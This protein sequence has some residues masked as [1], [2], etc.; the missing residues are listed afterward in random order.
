MI[1]V[2]VMTKEKQLEVDVPFARIEDSDIAWYWI[3]FCE[4][5]EEEKILL[6]TYFQFHPLA[7][8]DC[9]HFLQRPKI[10]YYDGYQFFI[11][12]EM[13]KETFLGEE[14][15]VF[16]SD[17]FIITYHEK[18]SI[19][20]ERAWVKL[21]ASKSKKKDPLYAFY[22]ILDEIVDDYFPITYELEDKLNNLEDKASKKMSIVTKE[23]YHIRKELL[24]IRKIILPMRELLYRILN[25]NHLT[26][27]KGERSYFED[28][29]DHLI[30][31]SEIIEVNR[32]LSSDIR[33]N[34]LSVNAHRMNSIM[35]VLTVIT[36]IFMPLTFIAGVY[37]MN[38]SNMPELQTKYGYFVVLVVMFLIAW[39]MF[40]W[41][42][43][44]GWFDM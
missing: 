44:K 11:L 33:D 18:K 30:R 13:N 39:S 9:L 27:P 16:L 17:T 26:I 4:P 6:S 15:N 1:R 2:L 43:R 14:V 24:K 28:V 29:H 32:E 12:Q 36:T 5:N 20:I 35:M 3:D 37:G 38:F 22:F 42:R 19:A 40:V 8:E 25:S 41:F 34:Y 10:D 23:I 7:I 21:T 31:L